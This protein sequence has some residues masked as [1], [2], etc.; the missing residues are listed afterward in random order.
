[1]IQAGATKEEAENAL[2]L[3]ELLRPGIH[4]K[5]K[6]SRSKTSKNYRKAYAGQG[7]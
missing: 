5:T 4:V 7:R 3:W 2:K 6:N 1:M